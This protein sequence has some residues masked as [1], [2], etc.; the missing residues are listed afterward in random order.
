MFLC[1]CNS[2]LLQF[3]IIIIDLDI[4]PTDMNILF[5]S[6]LELEHAPLLHIEPK[7]STKQ[8]N[9]RILATMTSNE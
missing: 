6:L 7:P 4:N 2:I 9:Q 1:H 5:N 8:R 3:I